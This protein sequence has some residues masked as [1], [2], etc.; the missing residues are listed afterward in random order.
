MRFYWLV[1]GILCVWRVTHLLAAEDGP[2]DLVVRLR[3][4][5]GNGFFGKLL[6]CFYCLSLWV[7]APFAYLLG[8]DWKERL[9]LWLSLSAGAIVVE[10]VTMCGQGVLRARYVEDQEEEH[11]L[12]RETKESNSRNGSEPGSGSGAGSSRD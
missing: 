12:L 6:D 7:A 2:W 9:L 1:L 8:D 4:A 10:R 3:Q 5:A 11:G